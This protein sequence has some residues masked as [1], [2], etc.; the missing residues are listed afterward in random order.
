MALIASARAGNVVGG[1]DW[2]TDRLVPD[3]MRS[4]LKGDV[5]RIRNPASFRPWQHVLEPLAGYLRLC[6]L[7]SSGR[8]EVATGWNFGPAV[9][10][11]VKVGEVVARLAAAWGPE[12]RFATD[13]VS[14]AVH[15][16]HALRLDH[17]RA[18]VDLGWR[19][20]LR[21]DD[22][23]AWIAEWYRSFGRGVSARALCEANIEQYE[24]MLMDTTGTRSA[25]STTHASRGQR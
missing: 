17:T 16:A 13:E 23:L 5:L 18:V 1:G 21:L 25:H 6:E 3:A 22:A 10:D 8:A 19:P 7:L 14:D 11:T 4:W 24:K 15:E 2:A 9:D 20:R 12:A